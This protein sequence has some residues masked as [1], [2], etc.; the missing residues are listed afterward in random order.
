MGNQH[1]LPG[2]HGKYHIAG[3][4]CAGCEHGKLVLCP[5]GKYRFD[6]QH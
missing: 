5:E 3:S 4:D 2:G 1:N 6:L